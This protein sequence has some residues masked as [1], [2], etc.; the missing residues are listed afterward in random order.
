MSPMRITRA[1][2]V[3]ISFLFSFGVRTI[4]TA[5]EISAIAG[6]V[7]VSYQA[8]MSFQ[9][10]HHPRVNPFLLGLST[11]LVFRAFVTELT[12]LQW[13]WCRW[14]YIHG[15]FR[16]WNEYIPIGVIRR[17]NTENVTK[18]LILQDRMRKIRE[19]IKWGLS[20]CRIFSLRV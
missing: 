5:C 3:N 14:R 6:K 8:G 18:R 4:G 13:Y 16:C 17:C 15:R 19:N 20:N 11:F 9:R 1:R 7:H 10:A 2:R 12:R